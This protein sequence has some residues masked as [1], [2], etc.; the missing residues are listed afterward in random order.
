MKYIWQEYSAEKDFYVAEKPLSPYLEVGYTGGNKIG[1][2][3]I[4]RFQEI[5]SPLFENGRAADSE[6]LENFLLHYLAHLDLQSG[7]HRTSIFE[8]R[9]DEELRRGEF[10][11]RAAE[12]YLSLSENAQR[13]ILIYLRRHEAARGLKNFFFDAVL[14]FFPQSKFYFREWERKFLF[15]IPSRKT[16]RAGNLMELLIFLLLDMGVSYE[17]FWGEQFGIIGEDSTMKLGEF[18][19][20]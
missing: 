4:P 6:R 15:C 20:Y 12:I 8:H 9:L 11:K 19:I 2:N 13:K 5:F 16:E 1:V 10:G 17:I 14:Q 3:I 18:V 7:V